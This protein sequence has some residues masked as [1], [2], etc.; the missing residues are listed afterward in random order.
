MNFSQQD[1]LKRQVANAAIDFVID[2]SIIG[3]GSGTTVRHFINAIAKIKHRI[4]GA[5]ASSLATK[6]ALELHGILVYPLNSCSDIDVYFDGAD[7]LNGIGQMIKGGGGALTGEK[8]VAAVSSSF[9][10]MVDESKLLSPFGSFPIA[11]EVIPMASSYV[12]RESIKL[13]GIPRLREGFITDSGNIILDVIFCTVDEPI[14][15]ENKLDQIVGV[16]ANGLFA[17]KS[18][19][20]AVIGSKNG[21]QIQKYT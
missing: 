7:Q 5:V 21:I 1:E 17:K 18:A 12:A 4:K 11:I 9:V 8:I 15:L 6:E 16:V 14:A 20:L 2:D 19:S 13:G 3:V 10:C